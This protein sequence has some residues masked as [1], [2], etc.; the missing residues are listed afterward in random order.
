MAGIAALLAGTLAW[1]YLRHLER[2]YQETGET[3]PVLVTQRY[4]PRGTPL[5]AKYFRRLDTPKA[6]AVP[7]AI[8]GFDVLESTPGHP[9]FRNLL[10]LPQGTP[11]A[12]RD[13]VALE[14]KE[15]LSQRI[16][17]RHVAVSFSL[18]KARGLAGNLQPGDLIDL[19]H[20]ALTQNGQP[21]P[22]DTALLFQAVPILAVNQNWIRLGESDPPTP[23]DLSGEPPE[24]TVLTVQLNPMAALRLTQIRESG[25]FSVALRPQGDDRPLEDRP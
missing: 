20:T 19:F 23:T 6:Y 17:E 13:L 1:S 3:L 15:A 16:P 22:Q 24:D 4:L 7:G 5:R 18:N 11:L 10:A 8:P 9:R 2:S 14:N 12:Q 25:T 21:T